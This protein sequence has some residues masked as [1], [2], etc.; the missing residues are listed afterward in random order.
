MAPT[1]PGRAG[2]QGCTVAG[3]RSPAADGWTGRK[4]SSCN[5]AETRAV[6]LADRATDTD[7]EAS[8][9]LWERLASD[10]LRRD[11]R[12]ST[13]DRL[14][15]HTHGLT[16]PLADLLAAMLARTP[17]EARTALTNVIPFPTPPPESDEED[18]GDALAHASWSTAAR[19]RVRA[20]NVLHRWADAV[21]DERL[22]WIDPLAPLTNFRALIDALA[23]LY[24]VH[25]TTEEGAV[26]TEDDL[27]DIFRRL[28]DAGY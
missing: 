5:V 11:P 27:D 3:A 15:G 25:H 21:G 16:D 17:P 13:Y 19:I 28:I 6:E 14:R 10:E 2:H 1:V 18:D 22:Q 7:D 9:E 20:R 24:A 12:I 4:G 26:L 8:T 23:W